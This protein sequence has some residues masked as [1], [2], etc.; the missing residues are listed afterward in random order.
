MTRPFHVA[1]TAAD[2]GS[3]CPRAGSPKHPSFASFFYFFLILFSTSQK[4]AFHQIVKKSQNLLYKYFFKKIKVCE[5]VNFL[6]AART[7]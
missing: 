6:P 5:S 3:A 2:P 4:G 1:H 7:A